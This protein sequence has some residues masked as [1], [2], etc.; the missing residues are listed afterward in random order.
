MKFVQNIMS[1]LPKLWFW[2]YGMLMLK[3]VKSHKGGLH[4]H[5]KTILTR[6]TVLGHNTNFNGLE[7]VGR[8]EVSFGDNFHSGKGCMIITQNH[9]YEGN[10]IPYDNT[11]VIK[12]VAIGDNVW[13]GNRVIILGGVNIGEGAIV[14]AGAVV[15][16]DIPSCAIAGGNPAKVFKFRDQEHY[17]QLKAQGKFH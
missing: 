15:V 12:D 1:M 16:N 8:G 13:L 6:N 14:Q 10:E 11:Y 3:V 4:I 17:Y 9:N 7:V 5:G 2:L